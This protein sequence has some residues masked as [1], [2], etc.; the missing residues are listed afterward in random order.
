M[1]VLCANKYLSI[2]CISDR[3]GGG[4]RA[5][6]QLR[7]H[8]DGGGQPAGEEGLPGQALPLQLSVRVVQPPGRPARRGRQDQIGGGSEYNLF[9]KNIIL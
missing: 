3:S 6:D 9:E 4:D 1:S 2:H 8:G 5:D 7:G